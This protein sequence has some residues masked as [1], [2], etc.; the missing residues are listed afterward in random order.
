MSQF[1]EAVDDIQQN[2]QG[3]ESLFLSSLSLK[4]ED[5]KSL[6][7]VE[8]ERNCIAAT[9]LMPSTIMSLKQDYDNLYANLE[10]EYMEAERDCDASYSRSCKEALYKLQNLKS[11]LD[12]MISLFHLLP[13]LI[14]ER[15]NR[16]KHH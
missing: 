1:I 6:D 11:N 12:K 16:C 13:V 4:K 15:N 3:F 8:L 7:D 5:I 9:Y 10:R 2:I 14:I